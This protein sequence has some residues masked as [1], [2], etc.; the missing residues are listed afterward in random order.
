[1]QLTAALPIIERECAQPNSTLRAHAARALTLLHAGK[2]TC[3]DGPS[4]DPASEL[5]HLQNGPVELSMETDVGALRIA[6]DPRLAPVAVSRFADLARAGFYDGMTFHRVIPGFLVQFGDRPEDG[7]E[8][9]VAEA[10]RSEASP[11]P[12]E[13]LDVGVV[14]SGKDTG[15]TQLFVALAREPHF[16]GRYT[17]IGHASGDFHLLGQ[18]DTILRVKVLP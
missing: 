18:G 8:T 13:A 1:L 3:D 9:P 4:A 15:Q 16:D 14:E 7:G 17:L 2:A 11:L 5:S 12:F 6:L 10:L